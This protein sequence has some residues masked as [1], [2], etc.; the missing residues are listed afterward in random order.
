ME[1]H[2]ILSIEDCRNDK[3]MYVRDASIS[4]LLGRRFEQ[5]V[6]P[7]PPGDA[8]GGCAQDAAECHDQG[9]RLS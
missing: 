2:L 6:M 3:V 9:R 1:T 5:W 4:V 7:H 8:L